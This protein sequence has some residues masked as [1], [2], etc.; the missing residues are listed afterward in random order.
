MIDS[1][2]SQILETGVERNS[3]KRANSLKMLNKELKTMKDVI[4]SINKQ[5]SLKHLKVKHKIKNNTND[6]S[7]NFIKKY[8]VV[9][10]IKRSV[11]NQP[12]THNT[13]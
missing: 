3:K 4:K 9:C 5:V 10:H 7:P 8:S 12:E 6:P 11:K 1:N 13:E 2:K